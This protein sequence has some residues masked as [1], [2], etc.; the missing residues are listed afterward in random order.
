MSVT[1][2]WILCF[3]AL[4][5]EMLLGTVY[6]LCVALGLA[7][8]AISLYLVPDTLIALVVL[9]VL[10]GVSAMGVLVYRK[11]HAKDH[12][13]MQALDVGQMVRITRVRADGSAI[14]MYRG[15]RWVAQP[16]AGQSLRVGRAR[17]CATRG[18]QLEVSM[19]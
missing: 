5:A 10:T 14:V 19:Q 7:G 8:A 16:I 17:I 15:A 4:G 13:P 11:K 2:C 1:L 12:D 18:T 6:L 3:V 9:G